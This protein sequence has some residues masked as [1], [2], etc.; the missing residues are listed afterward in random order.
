MPVLPN[1]LEKLVF[2][3]L[4]LGPGSFLDLWSGLGLQAVLAA[5]RLGVFEA[6]RDGPA[7]CQ[8]AAGRLALDGRAGGRRA[9]S[10]W[11]G[12]RGAA[13][14]RRAARPCRPGR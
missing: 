8:E 9:V 13:R 3:D 7:S 1:A 2:V 4:N 5:L 12:R 11:G 14:R 10:R 6:L